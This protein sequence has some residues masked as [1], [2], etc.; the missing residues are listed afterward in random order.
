MAAKPKAGDIVFIGPKGKTQSAYVVGPDGLWLLQEQTAIRDAMTNG[1]NSYEL[2]AKQ[3]AGYTVAGVFPR[4]SEAPEGL[5]SMK[6]KDGSVTLLWSQAGK[7]YE[8][9]QNDAAVALELFGP[10]QPVIVSASGKYMLTEG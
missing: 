7:S 3:L 5:Y 8:V 10:A 6:D 9:D 2:T 1:S 4:A